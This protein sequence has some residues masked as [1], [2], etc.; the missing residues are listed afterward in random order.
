MVVTLLPAM[1]LACVTQER[2]AAPFICTVHA[3]HNAMPQPNFVPVKPNTS[4]NTHSSGISG[5]TSTVCGLPFRVN[6]TVAIEE[7]PLQQNLS[8]LRY[9]QFTA[10]RRALR[11]G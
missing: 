6:L 1:L 8:G 9:L 10:Q 7:P 4:R 3:P 11:A 5:T 2:V